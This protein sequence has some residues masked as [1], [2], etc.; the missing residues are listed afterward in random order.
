VKIA[1]ALIFLALAPA[2]IL[3][4]SG[5]PATRPTESIAALPAILPPP[6]MSQQYSLLDRRSIF[7]RGSQTVYAGS[8]GPTT[9]GSSRPARPEESLVFNGVTET[10]HQIVAF[11]EDTTALKVNQY[12]VGDSVAG[13]KIVDINL[14]SLQFQSH[15][16][17]TTVYVGQNLLGGEATNLESSPTSGGATGPD[18]DVVA[19]MRARR[20]AELG[21]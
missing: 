20:Q 16:K 2:A 17:T 10:D 11:I 1:S 19:R 18:S 3:A 6:P 5:A 14:D 12:Q 21:H 7:I 15:G 13:G 4:Q 8:G 9:G